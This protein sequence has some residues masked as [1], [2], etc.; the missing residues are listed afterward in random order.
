MSRKSTVLGISV[1]VFA[2]LN[3]AVRAEVE[4][5]TLAPGFYGGTFLKNRYISVDPTAD[6]ANLGKSFAIRVTLTDSLQFADAA[7]MTWWVGAPLETADGDCLAGLVDDVEGGLVVER[8]WDACL[9]LQISGC[10]IVPVSDYGVSSVDSDGD[11]PTSLVMQTS[12]RPG[13][14]WWAD[15]TGF[16]NG[17][18][19]SPP[20][21][22]TSIGDFVAIIKTFQDVHAFNAAPIPLVDLHPQVPNRIANFDD[23]IQ[24]IVAFQGHHYPY[25]CPDDPCWDI[26]TDPC[27]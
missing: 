19:W 7:G 3:V 2:V 21:G 26:R 4:A 9:S 5:P 11:S 23:V 22:N 12:R 27:P 14:K 15:V 16:F 20:N 25:G 13:V 18:H 24:A 8:N 10:G 1:V 6:G 17:T